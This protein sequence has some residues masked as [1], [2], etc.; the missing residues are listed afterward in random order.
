MGGEGSGRKPKDT[1][2]RQIQQTMT[3]AGVIGSKLIRDYVRGRDEHGNIVKVSGTK[4]KAAIESVAHAIGTPTQKV[5]T[6]RVGDMTLKELAE[7][8]NEFDAEVMK[9]DA[10]SDAEV[11]HVPTKAIH[12][13]PKT[14]KN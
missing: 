9:S 11:I 1:N 5:I 10:K 7:L 2:T 3:E 12:K 14:S 6:A 13:A 8:A 4:L